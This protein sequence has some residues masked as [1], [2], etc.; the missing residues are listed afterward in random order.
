VFVQAAAI[1]DHLC[2]TAQSP[3]QQKKLHPPGNAEKTKKDEGVTEKVKEVDEKTEVELREEE[4]EMEQ[5]V[6]ENEESAD[7]QSTPVCITLVL[8]S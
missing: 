8:S 6:T 4:V 2:Q 5:G 3:S 7:L 1:V